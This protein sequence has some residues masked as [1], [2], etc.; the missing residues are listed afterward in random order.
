MIPMISDRDQR[1]R[2]SAEAW[3][4]RRAETADLV[5]VTSTLAEAFATDPVTLW[6]L[7]G[8]PHLE[9]SLHVMF[10]ALCGTAMRH[11]DHQIYLACSGTGEV[12]AVAFWHPVGRWKLSTVETL[13]IIPAFVRVLGM[14]PTRGLRLLSAMEKAHPSAPHYYLE[15][16]GTT[17][18][19]RGAGAG[20]ALMT[21]MLDRCDR[22]GI[23]AYLE[24]SNSDNDGFYGA[25]GFE[26][27]GRINLPKGCPRQ[28]PMWRDPR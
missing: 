22:E 26:V 5:T 23:S 11:D 13:R 25:H 17:L 8:R 14:R 1:R 15:F 19:A 12:A 18:A 2:S 21:S 6:M 9:R 10:R 7:N 3:S 27:R 20:T 24:N 16:I 4:V 28:V